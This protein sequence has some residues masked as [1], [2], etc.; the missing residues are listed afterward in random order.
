MRVPG[1][2]RFVVIPR[3]RAVAWKGRASVDGDHDMTT[4]KHFKALVR[5]RMRATGERYTVARRH[6]EAAAPVFWELRGGVEGETAAFANVLANLGVE[7]EGEPLSEAMI[8][9]TGGGLGAGYILWEFDAWGYRALT[10]GFRR[11]WQYPA[12]WAARLAERLGLQAEIHE[13]GGRKAAAEALAAQLDRGLPAIV[14]ID[15]YQLGHRGLPESRDG[16]GGWPVVVYG[17]S[18]DGFLVDDRSTG[19]EVVSGERLAAARARV[20][21]FK[22]RLIAIDPDRVELGDLRPAVAEG[23]RLQVEH[24]SAKSDSFS[25]PAW[26]K[27]ARMTTD[28]RHKKGWPTVFADGRGTCSARASIYAGASGGAHLRGLYADFLDEASVL[29]ERELPSAPWRD[30][31][32]AWEA[33]VDAALDPDDELRDLIDRDDPAR[34]TVQAERDIA[35]EMP[36]LGELVTA[37]YEA[38]TAALDRLRSAAA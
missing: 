7:F 38:E 29:L 9:G 6:V 1:N 12:R 19:R 5:D 10:L 36:E 37:M 3:G 4:R 30:A 34:W 31:A 17:R 25:L 24:L 23:L 32:A 27:W 26:R 2:V 20:V 35:G 15:S 16:F 11:E 8:L 33:I 18:G 21:S 22:H 13:T 28:T 14:W